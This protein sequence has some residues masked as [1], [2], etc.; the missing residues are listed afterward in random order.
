MECA[1]R[2]GSL[3]NSVMALACGVPAAITCVPSYRMRRMLPEF[4]E[5]VQRHDLGDH[6][7][8]DPHREQ[9]KHAARLPQLG[10]QGRAYRLSDALR[11]VEHAEAA[12]ALLRIFGCHAGYCRS[13]SRAESPLAR[14]VEKT[15]RCEP[16][17][18]WK[19]EIHEG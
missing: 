5:D 8:H 19:S 9:R 15:G 11:G 7:D 1:L 17:E 6:G 2:I 16:D 4:P 12:P 3:A 18:V 13:P 10:S 14:V